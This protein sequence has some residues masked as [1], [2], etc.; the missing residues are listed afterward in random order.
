M[1][2]AREYFIKFSGREIFKLYT[3]RTKIFICQKAKTQGRIIQNS[4][5]M[6]NSVAR[7]L[8]FNP[9]KLQYYM[10]PRHKNLNKKSD[11]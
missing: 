7:K 6:R 3:T 1:V 5:K 9:D 2:P 8:A 10:K 4:L 11:V